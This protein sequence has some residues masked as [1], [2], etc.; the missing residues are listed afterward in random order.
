MIHAYTVLLEVRFC[1][2]AI[3]QMPSLLLTERQNPVE[4]Q[5]E[6]GFSVVI[7]HVSDTGGF[8]LEIR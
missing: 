2:F 5:V 1:Y 3:E 8:L 4:V 7:I 6:I